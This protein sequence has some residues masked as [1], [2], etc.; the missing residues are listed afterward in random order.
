MIPQTIRRCCAWWVA[1]AVL[2]VA[3]AAG[4]EIPRIRDIDVYGA[5]KIPAAQILR[6]AKLQAGEPL[7]VSKGELEDR[8]SKIAGIQRARVEAVCCEGADAILFVGVEERNGAHAVFRSEPNGKSVLPADLASDY[9]QFVDTVLDAVKQKANSDAVKLSTADSARA[10]EAKF[11]AF[12]GGHL[13]ELRDVLRNSEDAG[14]RAIAVAVI[15]YA[16]KKGDVVDDLQF[17]LQDP[18]DTVRSNAMRSLR[19]LA[20][21][22]SKNPA[23]GVRVSPTWLIELLNSLVLS[24]RLG[25]ADILV[26]LSDRHE[27]AVLDQMRERALPALAEMAR[28]PSLRYAL[29]PFLLIGRIAGLDEQEIQLRWTNGEREKVIQKALTKPGR[30]K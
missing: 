9:E 29:P 30:R 10:F 6:E 22:S 23:S 14:Q 8:I 12:T 25:A 20:L 1:F 21:A 4:P 7:P 18:D 16:P 5:G 19:T 2:G 13:A 15:G 3:S 24:D 27:E 11:A 26:T 28:W 17:A